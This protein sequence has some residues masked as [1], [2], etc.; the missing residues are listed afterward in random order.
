MAKVYLPTQLR[1]LTDGIMPI[2]VDG[3]T[4]RVIIASLDER[5][6]GLGARLATGDS[7]APGLAIS[8]DGAMS[9]RGLFTP[10]TPNSEVHFHPAI[11]G[12]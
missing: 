5:F 10:V 6:P 2:E 8:V 1:E 4:I 9:S 7:L 3:N 12:G 11:G